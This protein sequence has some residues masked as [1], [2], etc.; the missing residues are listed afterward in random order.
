MEVYRKLNLLCSFLKTDVRHHLPLRVTDQILLGQSI[1]QVV[2]ILSVV[3]FYHSWLKTFCI[4]HP[5]Q[6]PSPHVGFENCSKTF[7]ALSFWSFRYIISFKFLTYKYSFLLSLD[8]CCKRRELHVCFWVY[9]FCSIQ[10]IRYPFDR[11]YFF[12]TM[13][14]KI[15][16]QNRVLAH[17]HSSHIL[18]VPDEFMSSSHFI[19]VSRQRCPE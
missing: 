15:S 19:K 10:D 8:T 16:C 5:K 12:V 4:E 3:C 1:S 13:Y 7:T 2:L 14:L 11:P 18:F 17:C 6:R 9:P